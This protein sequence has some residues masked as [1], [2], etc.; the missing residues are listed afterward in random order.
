MHGGIRQT[1]CD[2]GLGRACLP[3]ETAAE[4]AQCSQLLRQGALRVRHE[5]GE[6]V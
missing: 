5:L 6:E 4:V 2:S 3:L 1:E